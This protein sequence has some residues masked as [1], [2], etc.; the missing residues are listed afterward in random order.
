[1]NRLV[2]REGNGATGK[3]EM[4]FDREKETLRNFTESASSPWKEFAVSGSVR[5]D[6]TVY[7][8]LSAIFL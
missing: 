8:E 7:F 1:M 6:S 3:V 5:A 4:N 2:E